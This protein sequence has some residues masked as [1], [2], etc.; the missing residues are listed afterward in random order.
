M[1]QL[2]LR[3]KL[4]QFI[5]PSEMETNFILLIE[6]VFCPLVEFLPSPSEGCAEFSWSNFRSFYFLWLYS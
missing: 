1:M 4:Q 6:T 3:E 2:A 5:Q